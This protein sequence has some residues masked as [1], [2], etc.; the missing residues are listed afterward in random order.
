MRTTFW[1]LVS[2]AFH[3]QAYQVARVGFPPV[4]CAP[5]LRAAPICLTEKTL[6]PVA[7]SAGATVWNK[8]PSGL[9]YVDEAI[10]Q[11]EPPV[12]P[13]VLTVSCEGSLLSDGRRVEFDG[14][15]SPFTVVLGE[16]LPVLLEMVA[17]MR[18][19]G[20]RRV[21]LPPSADAKP[22]SGTGEIAGDDTI[23]FEVKVRSRPTRSPARCCTHSAPPPRQTTSRP[24]LAQI[25]AVQTG[26]A[27]FAATLQ[28]RSRRVRVNWALIL[29]L[30]SFVPY[31]LPEEQRPFMWQGNGPDKGLEGFIKAKVPVQEGT[32]EAMDADLFGER[33]GMLDRDLYR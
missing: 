18:V 15:K 25:L 4:R 21:L 1:C 27:A 16:D 28:A 10:G 14:R 5:A 8:T 24:S 13:Q 26:P 30:L 32:E 3:A 2:C 17:G 33:I 6:D 29:L 11:D 31:Y 20:K 22:Q 23:R 9:R 12:A 7:P 19:G